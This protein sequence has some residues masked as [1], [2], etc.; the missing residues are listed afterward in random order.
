M[1]ANIATFCGLLDNWK[2][3]KYNP[4]HD[5]LIFDKQVSCS[6]NNFRVA[7]REIAPY[8]IG[9]VRYRCFTIYRKNIQKMIEIFERVIEGNI[10]SNYITG[11]NNLKAIT[12]DLQSISHGDDLGTSQEADKEIITQRASQRADKE[13]I[14]EI[15]IT[16]L[17]I[18]IQFNRYHVDGKNRCIRYDKSTNNF[19]YVIGR[20]KRF[21]DSSILVRA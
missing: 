5:T 1:K 12:N 18:D 8:I 6:L 14:N 11:F 17:L 10:S 16:Q 20:G 13:K 19:Y 7:I 15:N 21:V 4:N 9:I 3:T 2:A